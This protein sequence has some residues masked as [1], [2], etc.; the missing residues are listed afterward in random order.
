MVRLSLLL[1]LLMACHAA[2]SDQPSL[3]IES[4]RF[5]LDG[6]P[7]QIISGR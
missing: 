2:A 6:K 3:A 7:F 5:M 1:G 4:D